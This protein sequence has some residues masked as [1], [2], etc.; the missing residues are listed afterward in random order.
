[1]SESHTMA[2]RGPPGSMNGFLESFNQVLSGINGFAFLFLTIT[3]LNY[4][5][6]LEKLVTNIKMKGKNYQGWNDSNLEDEP[7]HDEN[8]TPN[9]ARIRENQH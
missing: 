8:G 7:S 6:R 3:V 5:S 9:F 2:L 4:G 1:M